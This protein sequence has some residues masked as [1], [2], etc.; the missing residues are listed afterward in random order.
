M[1]DAQEII[2]EMQEVAKVM[3]NDDIEENP[4]IVD[5]YFDCSA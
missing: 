2:K 3:Y 5:E 4:D 1:K